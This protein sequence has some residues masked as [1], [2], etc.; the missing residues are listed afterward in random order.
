[1]FLRKGS[2][3]L[4]ITFMSD[5]CSK[6]LASVHFISPWGS[7][8]IILCLFSVSCWSLLHQFYASSRSLL[9]C[10]VLV[11]D[12][13]LIL[14]LCTALCGF[15]LLSICGTLTLL[16]FVYNFHVLFLEVLPLFLNPFPSQLRL[17]GLCLEAPFS[18]Q[19]IIQRDSIKNICT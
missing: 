18:N 4:S 3:V 10:H 12:L 13:C 2:L 16:P 15:F 14:S 7:L 17:L 8:S 9:H 6:L 5:R 19:L 1:M 11:A